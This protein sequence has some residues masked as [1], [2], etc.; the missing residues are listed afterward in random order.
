LDEITGDKPNKSIRLK[1]KFLFTD[2]V[3]DLYTWRGTDEKQSFRKLK[4][5]N[6]LI[7]TSVRQQFGSKYKRHEYNKYMVQ[8]IKHS[9]SRQRTVTYSYP[10]RRE[11]HEDDLGDD[12]LD[13]N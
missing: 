4:T 12:D 7:F 6:D 3:L 5:L 13:S 8:W 11:F 2:T 9:K 1:M 10:S